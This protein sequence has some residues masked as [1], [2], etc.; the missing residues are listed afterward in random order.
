M[1]GDVFAIHER[2]KQE[3]QY[4]IRS[5]YF[6]KN[7]LLLEAFEEEFQK[8]GVLYQ[9]P[10]LES[11]AV[12]KK[13]DGGLNN[14]SAPLWLKDFYNQLAKN[15][16][17]VYPAPYKHQVEA[18]QAFL[19]GKDILVST[20]TGS[21]K[22][23]CFMW[24]LLAK[25]AAEAKETPQSWNSRGIRAIIMYPMNALVNDQI[26]RLR[27]LIGD[28][29]GAFWDV[30]K[31][32][33]HASR[34][35]QFGMYTGR[36]PYPGKK[37]TAKDKDLA[38]Q[39]R[40]LTPSELDEDYLQA[41]RSSGR[42]PAKADLESFIKRLENSEHITDSND[43]E[44]ITRF[45][46]QKTCPDIL[47]TNYSM[48]EY[49]L[50]RPLEQTIWEST[51]NWLG[52]DNRLLFVIDEAHMYHG[53]TGGEVALLIRRLMH[54]LGICRERVQFILTTASM[55]HET[56]ED[57]KAVHK[58][59]ADLTSAVNDNFVLLTG[60]TTALPATSKVKIPASAFLAFVPSDN[61]ADVFDAL[62]QFWNTSKIPCSC[63][64]LL[65]LQNW[66]YEHCA[67][68]EPFR[69]LLEL[70]RGTA[71]S[72]DALGEKLFPDLNAPNRQEA[73]RNL[74]LIA[75]QAQNKTGT[76][77]FPVKLH[78][79]FRGLT[80]VYACTNPG[81]PH[82]HTAN[83]LTLG[84]I[85]HQSG[86]LQCPE[87]GSAV[88]ELINDR[89]CG[90][91]FLKGFIVGEPNGQKYLW[92]YSDRLV[93]KDLH[94]IHLYLPQEGESFKREKNKNAPRPCYLNTQ[95]GYLRFDDAWDD[96]PRIIKLYYSEHTEKGRPDLY[97]FTDCPH[98][99]SRLGRRELTPFRTRGNQSFYNLVKAQFNQEPAVERFKDDPNQGRKVLLFS[100]SRQRAARLAKDM[101]DASDAQAVMQLF[102]LAVL[103]MGNAET[104][105]LNDLYGYFVFAAAKKNVQLF[106]DER[107]G[108]EENENGSRTIFLNHCKN[109]SRSAERHSKR[110]TS[111]A[112]EPDMQ[113]SDRACDMAKEYLLRLYCSGYNNLYDTTVGWLEP[114]SK[115][116]DGVYSLIDDC[117]L[118]EEQFLEIF[119]AWIMEICRKNGAL[120]NCFSGVL[121][122]KALVRYG[123]F[124][125]ED[126]WKIPETILNALNTNQDSTLAKSLKNKLQDIFLEKSSDDNQYYLLLNKI[127][128]HI[129]FDADANR[130][131]DW[132]LC[133]R[134]SKVTPYP[135]AGHCPSCGGEIHKMSEDEYHALQFWTQPVI[136]A[137]KGS[138]VRV[139]NTEEHTAQ[140]SYKD[141]RDKLWSKTENYEMRFQNILKKGENGQS[142]EYPVDILSSTTTMEVGIDIG[143]LVAI[144]LRNI[145]PMRENYQQRAGRAGRRGTQLST[146]VTFCEDGPHDSYYFAAPTPML[147]GACRRPWIDPGND[148]LLYRHLNLIALEH[149]L[150][151]HLPSEGLDQVSVIDFF[152][153]KSYQAWDN[154][155]KDLILP[156]N[157][158]LIPDQPDAF[159]CRWKEYLKQKMESVR[160]K[161]Q[162]HP[163]LFSAN[164][165][166][167][168][169]QHKKTMLD[170]LY[171]E[172]IIPTFSFPKDVVHLYISDSKEKTQFEV[173]RGL[174]IAISEYAPGRA[175]VVDK[176]TYEIGGF[177]YPG[178]EMKKEPAKKFL[179]DHSYVS[180]IYL[181]PDCGWFGEHDALEGPDDHC[182]FCGK[183][184]N[185]TD[186]VRYMLRPWG[187]APK[188]GKA[189]QQARVDETY[190]Y[191]EQPLYSTVPAADL[192]R[193][194]SGSDH[195]SAALLADQSVIMLNKGPGEKGFL[196]CESC[197][198]AIPG[199]DETAFNNIKTPYNSNWSKCSH[200][201]TK[202]VFL[203]YSFVTDMLVLSIKLDDNVFEWTSGNLQWLRSA[204]I[205]LSEA[206]RLQASRLLDVEFTE[207]R[208]GARIRH[209]AKSVD[210]YLYDNL[211][212]GAGY[213]SE[214]A[215]RIVELL[216]STEKFL[217]E[218]PSG[219]TTACQDC[220]KHF[221][222][223]NYHHLLNRHF[224][225]ELVS[226]AFHNKLPAL[227]A[228]EHQKSLIEPLTSILKFDNIDITFNNN[229]HEI[230]VQSGD[231]QQ[232]LSIH[233]VLF[234]RQSFTPYAIDFTDYQL[235]YNRP[236][237]VQTLIELP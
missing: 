103:N 30:F 182:P 123:K 11:P 196:V 119:N 226:W 216:D 153:E 67:A 14:L 168:N 104:K 210:I 176:N 207:L 125:L 154:Y 192:M 80:G 61:E 143:S 218:C 122:D 231:H 158:V 5:Q 99:L 212:S 141:Q 73:L 194:I 109:V 133:E 201:S 68:Y 155:L 66:M 91:L 18:L 57:E 136:D 230:C 163:E 69:G 55:P 88:Y 56:A 204:A 126:S 13:A 8:K 171:E 188:N 2:I 203:G 173:D 84:Q 110:N 172:G 78:M 65:T 120:G 21:G 198:A 10:Y 208:T 117:R 23:E 187:F 160:Q 16:L 130:V 96:D 3:L 89:R 222:N 85:F 167:P 86:I 235:M 223:Q 74:L 26:S 34:R 151:E 82:S 36:T 71:V 44:M 87:C 174:D 213:S 221:Y 146:V 59:A 105:T 225:L 142:S 107:V 164:G 115:A 29:S 236:D 40:K 159:M 15:D 28:K 33:T 209:T 101:S 77:L 229:Q 128:P 102:A 185:S 214:L 150:S 35:P 47:I 181:C 72:L 25:H 184:L 70:C 233:P 39:L 138:P 6:G 58:F 152:E 165:Q 124:G 114:S 46:M 135:L 113:Y 50:M 178:A 162:K 53:S 93:N 19:D 98:C 127:S 228:Y 106:H 148:K 90:A 220:L 144:G 189:N 9:T 161:L 48:L 111:S 217:S 75:A 64:D 54:K 193:P 156:Q 43:A 63:N 175:L 12:Y 92:P 24:P 169:A 170:A 95:S 224:A 195:M 215:S 145:P 157:T 199:D 134:C 234:P 45:E 42:I 94:E 205:S 100:D 27:K 79:L 202:P 108:D 177:Y 49:M 200:Q 22:T 121:R 166:S 37:D 97:E 180:E 186:H 81:C 41:L 112:Y 219:C 31:Q 227:I 131:H 38:Q 60:A 237:V 4:Y 17:G 190:S 7:P 149:F 232:I 211:S 32:F 20:G 62:K 51:Q 1:D 206:V 116:E 76:Y 129:S 83:G 52:G 137:I 147:T 197:G 179:E 140:L 183:A 132:Y 139:I 118:Q 191:A